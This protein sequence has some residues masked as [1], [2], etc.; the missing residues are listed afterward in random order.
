MCWVYFF[1]YTEHP[2]GTIPGSGWPNPNWTGTTIVT[3]M[4]VLDVSVLHCI[5]KKIKFYAVSHDMRVDTYYRVEPSYRLRR[6]EA[7]HVYCYRCF[8]SEYEAVIALIKAIPCSCPNDANALRLKYLARL[9]SAQI[10]CDACNARYDQ[11][12][13]PHGH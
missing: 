7:D 10:S 9:V 11:P 13:G 5:G 1:Y 6:D 2:A 4:P 3:K 12:G 8:Y